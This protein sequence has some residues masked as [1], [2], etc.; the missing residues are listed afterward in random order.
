[1]TK[2]RILGLTALALLM[3]ASDAWARGAVS[4]GMR[5]AAVGGMMG[6][7]SGAATG[8]KIGVVDRRGPRSRT[9][10]SRSQ[11]HGC[12]DSGARS[13]LY[14]AGISECSVLQL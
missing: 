14:D 2:L 13:I 11:R 6:G 4:G 7:S 8:A 5:G 12:R 9:T 10:V 1:M 3:L